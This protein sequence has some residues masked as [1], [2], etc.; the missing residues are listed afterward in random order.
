MPGR[1]TNGHVGECPQRGQWTL[2]TVS[3]AP[4]RLRNRM[5]DKAR[6]PAERMAV[7]MPRTFRLRKVLCNVEKG[8]LSFAS[9]VRM[10][11]A[12]GQTRKQTRT[13]GR[14]YPR[15]QR[16]AETD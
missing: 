1:S 8:I 7:K 5:W 10:E 14:N 13:T 6:S 4:G 16:A 9:S 11:M 15:G 12:E 2:S 3:P